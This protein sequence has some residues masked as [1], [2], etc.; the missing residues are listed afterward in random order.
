M[1]L[2]RAAPTM[3]GMAAVVL[4]GEAHHA[5][6]HVYGPFDTLGGAERWADSRSRRPGRYAVAMALDSPDLPADPD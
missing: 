6:D 1:N 2:H 5:P 4:C 3:A